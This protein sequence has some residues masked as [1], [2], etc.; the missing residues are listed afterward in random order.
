MYTKLAFTISCL[1]SIGT[2][3]PC[4]VAADDFLDFPLEKLGSIPVTSIATGTSKPIFQSAA[5][6][7][8][9]TAEQIKSMGATEIHQVLE[10]VPGVHASYQDV[11]GDYNYSM[12]GIKNSTNSQILVMLNGTRIT[13]PFSGGVMDFMELPIEAIA[14]VEVIRGPGSALYGADAFAGIINIITKKAKDIKG[15]NDTQG[16][17]LGGRVG[18]HGTGSGWGQYG[19]QWAGWDVAAS[20]QYQHTD[21]DNGRVIAADA[22]TGLDTAFGTHASNAPGPMNTQYETVNAHLNLQR[23]HWDVD[24]WAFNSINGGARAGVVS[25]LDPSGNAN[26]EQYMGNIRY[27]TEDWFEDWEFLAHASYLQTD[28][29]SSFKIFPDNTTLLIDPTGNIDFKG[30]TP[31]SFPNGAAANLGRVQKVPAIELNSI[32]KGWADHLLRFGTSF[33]YEEITTNQSTNFGYGQPL[34]PVVDGNL[35]DV[36]GTQYVYLPNTHRSIWSGVVQDEWQFAKGWQLT[37]GVR[38]DHYSDFGGTTNPRAALVWDINKELT[39]KLLYGKAFRAPNFSEQGNQ[40]NPA[41][42][43]NKD[44]KPETINTIEWAFD[45]RPT[46][47]LRTALNLYYYKIENLITL[48]DGKYANNGNQNGYGTELEMNW[49]FAQDWNLMGNYAWQNARNSVT[50]AR[51]TGVP[52]H[53]IYTALRWQFLPQWQIQ[54]QLNWIGGRTS[55]PGDNR[56]LDDF[57]TIDLTLRGVKLFGHLNLAASIHNMFD[58]GNFEPANTSI[59]Y[60]NI[61]M[62]GR[63]YYFEVSTNF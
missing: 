5:V 11:V 17:V 39:T 51:V 55:E 46:S 20:V 50:D 43:G 32:Y 54:P 31:V 60:Q 12:R 56:P 62:P 27:S 26:G 48:L 49:Q 37:A 9:I 14:R 8:V 29:Q 57:E 40:N 59:P 19:A 35:V 7:S 16:G 47:S 52:E 44:L 22:Q 28:F 38:Y 2:F 63:S 45:Y 30:G 6:T 21:G 3:S 18:D 58:A 4:S 13:T 36:T 53:H 23:K 24:F 1:L 34:P 42:V 33:R 10:T 25:A 61:P 15:A 41:V